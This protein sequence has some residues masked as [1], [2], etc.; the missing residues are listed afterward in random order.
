MPKFLSPVLDINQLF[1]SSSLLINILS[2]LSTFHLNHNVKLINMQ[3]EKY[4]EE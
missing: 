1:P 3:V 2:K 4:S